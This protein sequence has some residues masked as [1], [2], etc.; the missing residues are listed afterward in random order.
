MATDAARVVARLAGV[1]LATEQVVVQVAT[2]LQAVV[3]V[4]TE[5]L[6]GVRLATRL[7]AVA[8]R[9]LP[10]VAFERLLEDATGLATYLQ[11]QARSVEVA[12]EATR[13]AE[14]EPRVVSF[15]T[16]AEVEVPVESVG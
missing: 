3:Q 5:L 13:V 1:Q 9:P 14:A 15:A 7:Q 11:R 6:A 8:A 2:G 12:A 4:A 16:R 10:E